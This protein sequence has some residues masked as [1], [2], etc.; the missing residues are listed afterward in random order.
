VACYFHLDKPK[1]VDHTTSW[2]YKKIDGLCSMHYVVFISLQDYTLLNVKDLVYF[3]NE[4]MDDNFEFV[5]E[6]NM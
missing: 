1:E 3:G 2:E 4:C 6:K 5:W